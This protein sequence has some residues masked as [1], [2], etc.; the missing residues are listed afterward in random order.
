VGAAEHLLTGRDIGSADIAQV[1]EIVLA[2]AQPLQRNGYKVPLSRAPINCAVLE[3]T[4]GA[5]AG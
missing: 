4:Q 2:D 3:L 5:P 1:A